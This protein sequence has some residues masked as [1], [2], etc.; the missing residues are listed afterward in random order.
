MLMKWTDLIPGDKIKI[1]ADK[2]KICSNWTYCRIGAILEVT[3][4]E[5]LIHTICIW[6]KPADSIFTDSVYITL[7][8]DTGSYGQMPGPIFEIVELKT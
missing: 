3:K 6:F 2:E 8:K 5:E 4:V 1:A 7:H